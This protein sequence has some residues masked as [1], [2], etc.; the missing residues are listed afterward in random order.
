MQI[1]QF[2]NL[3]NLQGWPKPAGWS[4]WRPVACVVL[5]YAAIAAQWFI[6]LIGMSSK[7]LFFS[8]VFLFHPFHT[9]PR[10]LCIFPHQRSKKKKKE[11]KN[12]S[13]LLS[14]LMPTW[15]HDMLITPILCR[16]LDTSI[17]LLMCICYLSFSFS[18]FLILFGSWWPENSWHALQRSHLSYFKS[19]KHSAKKATLFFK[20]HLLQKDRLTLCTYLWSN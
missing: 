13:V 3:I 1:R 2:L 14:Q 8:P 7:R 6:Y 19:G 17:H 11:K 4:S 16:L 20:L 18:F 15:A 10:A 12:L 5:I 9:F